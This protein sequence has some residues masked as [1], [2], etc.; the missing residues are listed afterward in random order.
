MSNQKNCRK[1]V[2]IL[3]LI[4]FVALSGCTNGEEVPDYAQKSSW[5]YLETDTGTKPCD[6]FFLAPTVY[7]GS[8]NLSLADRETTD[9]FR[10][11]VSMQKGIYDDEC[12][13][14]APYYRQMGLEEYVLPE[15]ERQEYLEFAY[16]D[17]KRA[18]EYY[19]SNYNEGRPI[20]LAGF[21]Q[22]SDMC[23]RLMKDCFSD[24]ALQKQLVACYAVG[25]RLTEE[26]CREYPQLRP[27]EGER[28]TGVIILFNS[29]AVEIE[30][31]LLIPKGV[32]TK[33][34]NPLNWKT[35]ST[36]ADSGEN[37]G[38]CFMNH[39]GEIE[40]E[41]PHLTGCF[42]DP[43]RGA[44]KVTDVKAEDYPSVNDLFAQGVYH[45]FDYRFFYRNLEENVHTRLHAYLAEEGEAR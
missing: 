22:G 3:F 32:K 44:L 33:A 41:I 2:W 5:A 12:R 11:A 40:E 35:D 43:E 16:Q 28:D 9:R 14:F 25:W 10:D 42:L 13:F 37:K 24:R 20:L 15:E 36:P 21:S 19:R 34:I 7:S 39:D 8:S 45:R 17:V 6:V 4:L 29:E 30:E 18:F 23:L 31:S 38:S 27:A 1:T 26:E